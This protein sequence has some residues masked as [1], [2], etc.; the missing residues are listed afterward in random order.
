MPNQPPETP[1]RQA[2]Q[3]QQH[4]PQQNHQSPQHAQTHQAQP[5]HWPPQ[6]QHSPQ[7]AQPHYAQQQQH[8]PQQ[9]QQSPQQAQPHY[10]QQQQQQQQPW[11]Q[12]DQQSPQQAHPHHAP[13]QQHWPQQNHA[14]PIPKSLSNLVWFA[15]NWRYVAG[16][17]AFL[18]AIVWL[19]V[20]DLTPAEVELHA[21][22]ASDEGETVDVSYTINRVGGNNDDEVILKD[23]KTPWMHRVDVRNLHS[24]FFYVRQPRGPCAVFID[25][26]P[27]VEGTDGTCQCYWAYDGP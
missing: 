22:G 13:Q 20:D 1:P 8:W 27:C 2:Q 6:N 18:A 24:V 17:A 23:V 25:G 7:Q 14:N 19:V 16:G 3:P 11:P 5:Q 12:Q 26:E 15:Q 9:N 21:T 4:R 10:A